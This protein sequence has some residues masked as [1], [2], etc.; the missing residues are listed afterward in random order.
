[1]NK[2]FFPDNRLE[3]LL[4]QAANDPGVRPEFYH[5]LLESDLFV[6]IVPSGLEAGQHTAR[7]GD[8]LMIKGIAVEGRKLIPVF[9]SELRLREYLQQQDHLAQLKGRALLPMIAEQNNGMLLNPASNYGKEF[10]PTEVAALVDGS[11]FQQ[12]EKTTLSQ[13]QKAIIGQAKEYPD[14]LAAALKSFFE[15]DSKVHKA[16]LAQIQMPQSNEPPHLLIAI[17]AEGDF[18]SVAAGCGI[19]IKDTLGPGQFVD[20][21]PLRGSNF[22]HDFEKITPFYQK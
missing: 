15:R 9:T 8:H 17:E 16:F 21:M 4:M 5:Q 1:M 6:L 18:E 14:K 13:N 11:I 10:T 19:V 3:A 20:L 2:K 22:E 7:Q 12:F